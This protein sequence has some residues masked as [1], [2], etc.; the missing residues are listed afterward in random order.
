MGVIVDD[1]VELKYITIRGKGAVLKDLK[2]AAK[3]AKKFFLTSDLD[4]EGEAIAWHLAQS[5]FIDIH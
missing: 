5:L 1:N 2:S 4:R 3:K